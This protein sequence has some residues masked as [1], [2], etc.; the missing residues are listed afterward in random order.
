MPCMYITTESCSMAESDGRK[1]SAEKFI[2]AS[3]SS[4]VRQQTVCVLLWGGGGDQ[5]PGK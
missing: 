1:E 4:I 5:A 3:A 2:C